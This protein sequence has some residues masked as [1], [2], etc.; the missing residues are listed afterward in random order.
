MSAP[1]VTPDPRPSLGDLL[2]ELLAQVMA[3]RTEVCELRAKVK[4]LSHMVTT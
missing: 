3:L 4:E 2:V 1:A